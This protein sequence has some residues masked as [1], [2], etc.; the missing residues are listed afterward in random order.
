MREFLASSGTVGFVPAASLEDE[1]AYFS[2]IR[3]RLADEGVTTSARLLD[4]NGD[5]EQGLDSV[6]AVLVGGGN[7]YALMH[8]LKTSG[9]GQAIAERVS[10]GM[11]Y[12]GSSAGTN[13]AGPNILTT[14]DWNVCGSTEF[15]GLR[16]V[17]C[18]LNVHYRA[19][20]QEAAT[21][22][23]REDRIGEY[24]LVRDNPVVAIEEGAAIEVRDDHAL[25]RGSGRGRVFQANA[26]PRWI[27]VGETI[28]PHIIGLSAAA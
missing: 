24:L 9:L 26:H 12:I 25:I 3:D 16:L 2:M 8:R 6:D 21:A 27:E 17:G 4:W 20:G 28:D 5:W 11:P 22:E 19:R 13:V 10:R 15:D 1:R 14:N 23:T 18:N 7:T